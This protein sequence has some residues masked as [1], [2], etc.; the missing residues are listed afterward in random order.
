MSVRTTTSTV[1]TTI[2]LSVEGIV[3]LST[4]GQ[5]HMDLTSAV[6]R[7]PGADLLVDLDAVTA[8][9]DVGLGVLLGAAAAARDAEGSL[10]VVAT[11]DGLR[12]RLSRARFDR[13]VDVRSGI[14]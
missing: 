9:D 14:A 2:V 11:N 10:S 6:R 1:G 4:V 13:A 7:H 5:F 8:L 3:D 12:T